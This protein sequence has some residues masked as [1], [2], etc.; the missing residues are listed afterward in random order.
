MESN[1]NKGTQLSRAE[2]RQ[3]QQDDEVSSFVLANLSSLDWQATQWL[4]T[5]TVLERTLRSSP[6]ERCQTA[7]DIKTIFNLAKWV[8]PAPSFSI[9]SSGCSAG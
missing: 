3:L 7:G 4:I 9:Y 5:S 1:T 8:H 2:I 6:E